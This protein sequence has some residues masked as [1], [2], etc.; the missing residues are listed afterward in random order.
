[1]EPK[2][3]AADLVDELPEHE[4]RALLLMAVQADQ[5]LERLLRSRTADDAALGAEMLE[6]AKAGLKI[7]GFIDYRESF[8]AAEQVAGVLDELQM[9]LEAGRPDAVAP[10]LLHALKRMRRIMQNADDSAGVLG[11]EE[12]RAA[13][14]YARACS[15]GNPD[16]AKLARWLAKYRDE[17]PG[18]PDVSLEQFIDG[19]GEKGLKTYRREVDK[20]AEKYEGAE[21]WGRHEYDRMRLELADHDGDV[22]AAVEILSR[23]GSPSYGAIV[24]RLSAAGREGQAMQ[25]VDRAVDEGKLN[26]AGNEFWLGADEVAQRYLADG[27]EED[28]VAMLKEFFQRNPGPWAY[29]Q[30][31]LIGERL[32]QRAP[33]HHWALSAAWELGAGRWGMEVPALELTLHLG[34]LELAWRAADAFGPG[35]HRQALARASEDAYPGKAYEI[36]R[37]EVDQ[38]AQQANTKRYAPIARQLAWMR[39]LADAAGLE[40][41]F[42]QYMRDIRATYGNRPRMMKE[43]DREGL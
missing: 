21:R 29:E 28:A 6:M 7:Y 23:D 30:L 4:A 2:K 38:Q 25:W 20:L 15:S 16:Q 33:L 22:D 12:R 36:V 34:D 26:S 5:G 31:I 35:R 19:L 24:Q 13:D 10:A 1:M 9:H 3:S 43:L 11:A 39:H 37:H 17:S 42:A 32:G 41:D 8:G 18:W 14:L 27:R 40:G